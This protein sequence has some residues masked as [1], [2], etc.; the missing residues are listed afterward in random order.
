MG[1]KQHGGYAFGALMLA[2]ITFV[3]KKIAG[4]KPKESID[5]D[6]TIPDAESSNNQPEEVALNGNELLDQQKEVTIQQDGIAVSIVL[7][8]DIIEQM[9]RIMLLLLF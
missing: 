3:W 9:E 6:I 5:E 2:I 8:S 7:S 1:W 4:K